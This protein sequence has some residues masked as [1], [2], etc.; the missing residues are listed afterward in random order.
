MLVESL[1]GRV[2][3]RTSHQLVPSEGSLEWSE[4]LHVRILAIVWWPLEEQM[5]A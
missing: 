4:S 2:E 5:A 3:R 1:N